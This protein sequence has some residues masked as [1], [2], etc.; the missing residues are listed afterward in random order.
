[1]ASASY[2][3]EL[4]GA[5]L[6]DLNELDDYWAGKGNPERGEQYVRD[7]ARFARTELAN[8]VRARVGRKVRAALI[9][10][11]METTAYKIYRLIYRV[12]EESGTVFVLRFW[13]SHRDEPP[14]DV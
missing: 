8:P 7:L 11:T 14:A 12:D 5:A 2:K 1:M 13:H 10:G 3:V 6:R 4:T 9:P